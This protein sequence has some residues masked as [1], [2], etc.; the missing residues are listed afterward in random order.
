M[1]GDPALAFHLYGDQREDENN[2]QESGHG[3]LGGILFP[4]VVQ[5]IEGEG[6]QIVYLVHGMYHDAS[7]SKS[8]GCAVNRRGSGTI[9]RGLE[10]K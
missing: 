5:W 10:S 3:P 9:R 6:D 2:H 8:I 4:E 7:T 1:A